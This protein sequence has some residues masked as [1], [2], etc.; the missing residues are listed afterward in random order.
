MQDWIEDVDL[1][2]V[3]DDGLGLLITEDYYVWPLM[4]HEDDDKLAEY[5]WWLER[6]KKF[7]DVELLDNFSL[8]GPLVNE[9]EEK[10]PQKFVDIVEA[11]DYLAERYNESY[12]E[13]AD[14]PRYNV[15]YIF[16]KLG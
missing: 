14:D 4:Y 16:V 5:D 1:I 13:S 11:S 6:K 15:A 8:P 12:R 2:N 10:Y 3:F 9:F 7:G